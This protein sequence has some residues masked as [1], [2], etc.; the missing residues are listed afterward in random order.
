LVL[1]ASQVLPTQRYKESNDTAI[2]SGTEVVAATTD[3]AAQD[4][5]LDVSL[6]ELSLGQRLASTSKSGKF[7]SI[8]HPDPQ[9]NKQEGATATRGTFILKADTPTLTR[10]LTQALH[11][12]DTPL[13]ESVLANS[14][15][16]LIAGTVQRLQPQYA[17]PLIMACVER[18]NRGAR[19]GR[20]KGRG[21]GAGAQRAGLMVRWIRAVLVA[22]TAHLMTVPDLVTRLSALHTSLTQRLALQDR[23][24]SLNGRLDLILSQIEH[25]AAVAPPIPAKGLQSNTTQKPKEQTDRK[26]GETF[27]YVE[28]ESSDEAEAAESNAMEVDPNVMDEDEEIEIDANVEEA[29]DEGSIEDVELGASDAESDIGADDQD[30]ADDDSE[31]DEGYEDDS[32]RVNG[33]LD[34]EAEGSSDEGESAS[35][36]E[37]D[38]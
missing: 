17:V 8:D 31:G 21:G 16:Q 14:S 30:E 38:E 11:S 35:E 9:R 22:H 18:M 26:R 23:L 27:K 4:G 1:V 28:G 29:E 19:A 13:L 33:F 34:I 32:P 37:S 10:T 12:N 25:R 2:R 15:R 5:T 3:D 20:G 6:A 36:D 7:G 24:L